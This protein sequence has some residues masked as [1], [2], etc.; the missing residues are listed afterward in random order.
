MM[1]KVDENNISCLS[2]IAKNKLPKTAVFI[3][4]VI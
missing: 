4:F 1:A 3:I 2:K